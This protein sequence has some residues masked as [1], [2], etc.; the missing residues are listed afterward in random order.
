LGIGTVTNNKKIKMNYVNYETSIIQQMEVRLVGWLKSVK[1]VNPS[2]I[3]TVLEI[4]T[5]HDDLKSG[6]CHWVKLTKGQ[7]D[8]HR[9]DMEEWRE[10]GETVDKQRKNRSD[11][12]SSRKRKQHLEDKEN[13][14]LSKKRMEKKAAK[15]RQVKSHAVVSDLSNSTDNDDDE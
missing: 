12:G 8:A 3:G 4:C 5:L 1:F 13:E 10:Q 2:Q 14:R 6:A 7:L 11:V 15:T 9:A